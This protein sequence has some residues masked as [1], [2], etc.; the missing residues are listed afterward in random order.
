MNIQLQ[1]TL[2]IMTLTMAVGVFASIVR[3][4]TVR[5][6]ARVSSGLARYVDTKLTFIGVIH[7][8]ASHALLSFISGANLINGR[9][10]KF[11]VYNGNL[12]GVTYS[13]RGSWVIKRLQDSLSGMAPI[14]C[15]SI[16][17]AVIYNYLI[18]GNTFKDANFWVGII[19]IMQISYH[20]TLSKADI[21]T[22][23]NGIPVL[24]MVMYIV[25]YIKKINIEI[26]FDFY[27]IVF[28]AMSI[29]LVLASI[30]RILSVV[31]NRH[32]FNRIR[33]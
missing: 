4:Y 24:F 29:N 8:E 31:S 7:H 25:A 26:L 27:K 32:K 30:V 13:P 20:M 19:V 1:Q 11:R 5:S 12:G 9:L 18:V 2:F 17:L 28:G 15:G 22:S 33:R 23:I 21:N 3:K 14:I 6:L 10:F 16:T